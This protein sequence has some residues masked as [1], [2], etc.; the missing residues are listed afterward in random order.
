MSNFEHKFKQ[1]IYN[2]LNA[3][4]DN[5]FPIVLVNI[6]KEY[7]LLSPI[8]QYQL[9]HK[10]SEDF[11][12]YY[13]C[14]SCISYISI[15]VLIDMW[16]DKCKCGQKLSVDNLYLKD[17]DLCGGSKTYYC[18]NNHLNTHSGCK[19]CY[20]GIQFC[21]LA[22]KNEDVCFLN[23]TCFICKGKTCIHGVCEGTMIEDSKNKLCI[24][25]RQYILFG[26]H[27]LKFVIDNKPKD[28]KNF[29]D[30]IINSASAFELI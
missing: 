2:V 6:I 14:H 21:T 7:A 19:Q 4:N 13:Y 9:K 22:K 11:K 29:L 3:T 26:K 1:V 10:T 15:N 28:Y 30:M 16:P 20:D 17:C 5:T 24:E 23:Q 8:L 25:C 12:I 18:Y 27:M